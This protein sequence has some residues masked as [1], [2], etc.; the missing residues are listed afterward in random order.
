MS[1]LQGS[2]SSITCEIPFP[3]SVRKKK[4][5]RP[6]F[7]FQPGFQPEQEEQ[8]VCPKEN[9]YCFLNRIFR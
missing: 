8:V 5:G 4:L 1:G 9:N 6:G 2:K 3:K 7:E